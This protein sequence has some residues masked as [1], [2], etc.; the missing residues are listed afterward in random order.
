MGFPRPASP[1]FSPLNSWASCL[2]FFSARLLCPPFEIRTVKRP[3]SFFWLE[4][5]RCFLLELIRLPRF[6]PPSQFSPLPFLLRTIAR[7]SGSLSDCKARRV[8]S[9]CKRAWTLVRPLCYLSPLFFRNAV[10]I[11]S[12][13]PFFHASNQRWYFFLFARRRRTSSPDRFSIGVCPFS[14]FLSSAYPPLPSS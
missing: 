2:F 14:F 9:S 13:S 11:P 6:F 10:N 7:S 8:E 4:I 5:S 12:P 1:S 3:P